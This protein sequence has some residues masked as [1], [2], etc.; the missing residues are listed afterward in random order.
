M[1]SDLKESI[2]N[3][4]KNIC[5]HVPAI[6]HINTVVTSRESKSCF[7]DPNTMLLCIKKS[8]I[9]VQKLSDKMLYLIC[10]IPFYYKNG[11]YMSIE[12]LMH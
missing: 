1:E 12:G 6:F 2:D 11:L 9:E 7:E 8:K 3:K 10:N 5:T 4:N